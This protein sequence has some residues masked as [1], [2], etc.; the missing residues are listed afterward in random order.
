[1][2]VRNVLWTCFLECFV[3]LF[4]GFVVGLFLLGGVGEFL[5]TGGDLE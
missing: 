4:F 1:M 5:I 3:D 2:N